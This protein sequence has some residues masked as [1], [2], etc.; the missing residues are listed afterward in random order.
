MFASQV[1]NGLTVEWLSSG[2]QLKEDHSEAV[3][4]RS[5]VYIAITIPLFGRHIKRGAENL[6]GYSESSYPSHSCAGRLLNLGKAE[7]EQLDNA[8]AVVTFADHYV[9]WFQIPVHH[10]H[11]VS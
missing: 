1:L 9:V 6:T 7:V 4:I 2:Y 5:S 8:L 3:D 11:R 10:S